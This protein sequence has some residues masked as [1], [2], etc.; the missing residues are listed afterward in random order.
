M[1]VGQG[2]NWGCSAKEKKNTAFRIRHKPEFHILATAVYDGCII[3]IIIIIIIMLK[4]LLVLRNTKFQYHVH[5]SV[6]LGP[7]WSHVY[8]VLHPQALF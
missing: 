8:L 7:I 1:E 5:K 4:K 6:H 3:I 2:P